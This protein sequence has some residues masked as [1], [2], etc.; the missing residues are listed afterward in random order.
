M[1]TIE[2][3]VALKQEDII[4]ANLK[5]VKCPFLTTNIDVFEKLLDVSLKTQIDPEKI[6][7]CFFDISREYEIP[8][9]T[10]VDKYIKNIDICIKVDKKEVYLIENGITKKS[11]DIK[12]K[13][14]AQLEIMS[15]ILSKPI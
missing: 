6:L 11:Y 15:K 7:R 12:Q 13:K 3:E 14:V 4:N 10:L 8:L 5:G 2:A 1:R 9:S